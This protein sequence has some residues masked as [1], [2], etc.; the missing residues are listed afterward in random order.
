MSEHHSLMPDGSMRWFQWTDRAL[1]DGEGNIVEYQ[2]VG[3]DITERKNT[4]AELADY[5]AR[6]E[7]LVAE[8]SAQLNDERKLLR[9][10]IDTIPDFISIK[11]TSHRFVLGN[12]ALAHAHGYH[13]PEELIG[14]SDA[15]HFPAEFAQQYK[16]DEA[17][18]L[19]TGEALLDHEDRV[20]VYHGYRW[21]S[22]TKIPLRNVSG[23]ITGLVV[24]TRDINE[25][26][27]RERQLRFHASVQESIY[28]AVIVADVD[29]RIQSW[30]H[31]AEVMY[32]WSA[33]E[34]VGK[35]F[36]ELADPRRL[37]RWSKLIN[38]NGRCWKRVYGRVNST[39]T[40]NTGSQSLSIPPLLTCAK[41]MVP[42]RS[43]L[44]QPRYYRAQGTG[45]PTTFPCRY[46]RER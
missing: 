15:D 30:N 36:S 6:L 45:T 18:I 22:S 14:K 1:L 7:Q 13:S 12:R 8:R 26:K 35:T 9:T 5:R 29:R 2:G 37:G 19:R 17:E 44:H 41:M 28:D 27:E 24:V 3:R 11:D 31:R 39:S 25:R 46:T 38:S 21:L 4:E 23:E 20:P 34:A 43:R 16:A 10:L 42:Y 40:I 32:G 33:A